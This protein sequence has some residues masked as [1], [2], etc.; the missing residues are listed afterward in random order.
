[1]TKA[2]PEHL[3]ADATMQWAKPED[4]DQLLTA[5][6]P[7]QS[8]DR[9]RSQMEPF[10]YR[11][12]LYSLDP[13]ETIEELQPFIEMGGNTVV[14]L[15]P[16]AFGRD[17]V[18]LKAIAELTGLNVIMGCGEYVSS[19]HSPYI[20]VCSIDQIH[21]V[22][23]SEITDGVGNTGIRAGIIG[24]IGSGNPV[25]DSEKKVLRAAAQA[26]K[27]TGVALNI[28][29]TVFPDPDAGLDA[30]EIVLEEGVDP[31]KV[32]MSHCDERPEPE[33]SLEVG[34]RGAFIE[35][36]TF[37]MEHWAANTLQK[38]S[39]VRRAFDRDRIELLKVLADAGYLDQLLI[40]QDVCMKTQ[41]LSHGG[42]GFA[43]ISENVEPV[44]L[45]Q[46]FTE[47][48]L[49]TIRVENPRRV[50]RVEE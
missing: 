45:Q 33:F 48:D 27:A 1:M 12:V 17:P 47:E 44:L 5:L 21:D 22:L 15:S 34:R 31:A 18:A 8:R 20:A 7:L 19:A 40:S 9:V 24:E 3:L 30:L 29:R 14:D 4:P 26:Q 16:P 23:V 6:G 11:S 38:G 42:A 41:R 49:K 25:T 46:G 2:G 43:H 37:G 50:L 32:I 13:L 39:P 10:F 36:D 35:L 28:H